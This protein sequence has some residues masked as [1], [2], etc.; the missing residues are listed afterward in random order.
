MSRIKKQ[1]AKYQT[2]LLQMKFFC[3]DPQYAIFEEIIGC[4]KIKREPCFD[5]WKS[6]VLN[7]YGPKWVENDHIQNYDSGGDMKEKIIKKIAEKPTRLSIDRLWFLYF[8]TGDSVLLLHALKVGGNKSAS[9][10]TINV[11][12]DMHIYFMTKYAEKIEEINNNPNYLVQHESGEFVK[13]T[14]KGFEMVEA[15]IEKNK[16]KGFEPELKMVSSN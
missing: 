7:L 8:A 11:I 13:K 16:Q 5:V 14:I 4:A 9:P 10:A 15:I 1:N 2:L 3:L 12:L 6:A